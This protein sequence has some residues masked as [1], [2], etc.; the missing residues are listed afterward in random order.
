MKFL[1]L[2]SL[3]LN[4]KFGGREPDNPRWQLSP[5]QPQYS[6]AKAIETLGHEVAVHVSQPESSAPLPRNSRLV[7]RIWRHCK[8]S[9]RYLMRHYELVEMIDE[10]R[11]NVVLC[12]ANY[13][14]CQQQP[15]K[16]LKKKVGFKFLLID[17]L[18]PA[19]RKHDPCLPFLNFADA[20][21]TNCDQNKDE[22]RKYGA[23]EVQTLPM[24]AVSGD[25]ELD[26][27]CA[28]EFDVGFVGTLGGPLYER[29]LQVLSALSDFN[30]G[31][32]TTS[33]PT[34]L[35]TIGLG[36]YYRGSVTRNDCVKVY[37]KCRILINI[38]GLHMQDG[39]N[40]STFEIALSGCLQLCD[41]CHPEWFNDGV[42]IVLYDSIDDL[43]S[44]IVYYLQHRD[45]AKRIGASGYLK[46][47]ERHT[48]ESRIN[49]LI[50]IVS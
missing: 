18:S 7:G 10:F 44:K 21:I 5:D 1:L 40:L 36:D 19:W 33:S 25:V 6:V 37:R 13:A 12:W 45:E 29:R 43:R 23:K 22:Y 2:T 20:V 15:I 27:H 48:F 39:G 46:V 28:Y 11:P 4:D 14:G 16:N 17:G 3:H 42:D 49:E 34:L 41:A 9:V 8:R 32:W 26:D 24:S 31:I 50:E 30:L 35:E 47:K 38:H